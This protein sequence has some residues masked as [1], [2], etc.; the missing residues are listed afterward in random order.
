MPKIKKRADDA[1]PTKTNSITV[2]RDYNSIN[3]LENFIIRGND[4]GKKVLLKDI[5]SIDYSTEKLQ[6][7]QVFEDQKAVLLTIV[8]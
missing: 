6:T 7:E 1:S 2:G 4:F 5:A 8:K 3:R